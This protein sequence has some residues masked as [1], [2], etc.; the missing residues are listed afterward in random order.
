MLDDIFLQSQTNTE[1][2]KVLEKEHQFLQTE[3]LKA[4]SNK[5]HFFSMALN[6]STAY[7]KTVNQVS[8]IKNEGWYKTT[9]TI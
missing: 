9:T 2:F 4:A 6:I 5:S 8:K 3:N 1:M 7:Q